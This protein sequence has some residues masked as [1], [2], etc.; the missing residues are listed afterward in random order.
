[1]AFAEPH[2]GCV[3]VSALL[4]LS[5]SAPCDDERA[6][7]ADLRAYLRQRCG[8]PTKR[9]PLNPRIVGRVE[10]DDYTLEKLVYDTEPSASIPAH[11]Y[12]PKGVDGPVPAIVLAHGH[13]GSKSVFFNQYAG[14]LYAKA[15]VAVLSTDPLGEEERDPDGRIGTRTHDRISQEAQSLGRPVLGAMVWDL[16]CGIDYLAT[17]P[18]V[19]S[20]RI[21]VAGHS[22]GA[23]VGMY[24]AALDERVSAAALA[25]M[26]FVPPRGQKFCTEGIYEL[27][28]ER[29]TYPQLL[30]LA[31]PRCAV[32]I[33]VGGDDAICGGKAVCEA[34]FTTFRSETMDQFQSLGVPEHFATHIYANAGHRAYFLK[35]ESLLWFEQHLGLPKLT[36]ADIRALPTVG[37]AEWAAANGVVF[38]QLY[39]TQSH[40]G[41]MTVPDVGVRHIDPADLACLSA[42]ERKQ[43][44]YS[45]GGWLKYV[46]GTE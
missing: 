24:L 16:M 1:M 20:A 9:V 21:G 38:E 33:P 12:L 26:Y 46:R 30:A 8:I 35:R 31:A 2:W 14:Q 36:L 19:D 3:L 37:M 23:I 22:L 13:G 5:S 10:Y 39:G 27:H 25:A 7:D 44:R 41:G 34:G 45:A 43:P 6:D 29:V 28:E 11:L 40:Y 4:L 32:F 42:E 15:G 17:R 18:E